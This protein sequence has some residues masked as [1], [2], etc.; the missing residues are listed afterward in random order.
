MKKLT[1]LLAISLSTAQ[2]NYSGELAA[3][4]MNRISDK[5][6]INLPY[7]MIS[8]N[9]GYTLGAIDINTVSGIE[10]RNKPAESSYLLR[11]A[12]L[13]YYPQWGEMKIGKQIHA[14][15]SVDGNNQT[16]NLNPYDYYYL[17]KVGEGRKI[18]VFSFSTKI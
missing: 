12:Y 17:F 7:R 2:I 1:I 3:K 8:F 13:A 10:Y 6:E 9:L 11:E 18:G 5:S 14:W 15:G 4:Y 16:D